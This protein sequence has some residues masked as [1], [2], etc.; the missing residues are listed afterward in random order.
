M[1]SLVRPQLRKYVEEAFDR[2]AGATVKNTAAVTELLGIKPKDL[3]ANIQDRIKAAREENV[4]LVENAERVYAQQV[5]DIFMDPDNFGLR[6]EELTQK[7]VERGNVSESRAELIARDQTLKLLGAINEERQTSA[8]VDQYE[9]STSNDDRV[10][11][12]HE[13]LQGDIIDWSSPPAVGHPG[14]DFQCRCVAIPIIPE[15]A[16]I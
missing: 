6:V 4:L 5:R 7:L 11:E 9:W 15:L 16:G 14:E 8:G 1:S 2:M 13:A 10:R 3:A 12:E